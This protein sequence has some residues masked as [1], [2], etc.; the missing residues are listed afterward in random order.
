MTD[1]EARTEEDAGHRAAGGDTSYISR[2][3]GLFIT[4]R[5]SVSLFNGRLTITPRLEEY[6][7]R[8]N[9]DLK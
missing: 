5:M 9:I 4:Q 1:R 6:L 2:C 8:K 3:V 7:S